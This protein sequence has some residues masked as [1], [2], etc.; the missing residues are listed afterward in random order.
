[1]QEWHPLISGDKES[2]HLAGISVRGRCYKDNEINENQLF[3]HI[4]NWVE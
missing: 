3:E 4:I 2:V 1:L